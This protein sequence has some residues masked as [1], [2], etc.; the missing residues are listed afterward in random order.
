[1]QILLNA[2]TLG[3]FNK[4]KQKY[5]YDVILHLYAVLVLDNC[6]KLITE[7][8]QRIVLTEDT[9]N[10]DNAP[11]KISISTNIKLNQLI[12]KCNKCRRR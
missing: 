1:M 6:A 7:K 3:N 8:N 10:R 2:I 4:E 5:G 12:S 11:D 9:N